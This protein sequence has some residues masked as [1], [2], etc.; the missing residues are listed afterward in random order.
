MQFLS[1]PLLVH[2]FNVASVVS[3]LVVTL[4][5]FDTISKELWF[6]YHPW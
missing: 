1:S 6:F 2:V 3:P 4:K 5:L